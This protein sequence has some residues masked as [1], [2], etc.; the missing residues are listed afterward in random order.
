VPWLFKVNDLQPV[1]EDPVS[2]AKVE[3]ADRAKSALLHDDHAVL[4]RLRR[5]GSC[6]FSTGSSTT[7][8]SKLSPRGAC[9]VGFPEWG[10]GRAAR[11]HRRA[12]TKLRPAR[13]R[14][15]VVARAA[16]G[17]YLRPRG[18]AVQYSASVRCSVGFCCLSTP[19]EV[20]IRGRAP[21]STSRVRTCLWTGPIGHATGMQHHT[22]SVALLATPGANYAP[23]AL[24][25]ERTHDASGEPTTL[26]A[27]PRRRLGG[28]EARRDR[29][30]GRSARDDR[31]C[32]A[33]LSSAAP[34]RGRP[35]LPLLP[36]CAA[37]ART[38]AYRPRA[39]LPPVALL[40][41]R[42][43]FVAVGEQ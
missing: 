35:L 5:D 30:R 10:P 38:A 20:R 23:F 15:G 17:G 16:M 25:P 4:L 28:S 33:T 19:G 26:P 7:Q 18:S 14:G 29:Q 32:L 37:S 2:G 21:L 24:V 40:R 8:E 39:S 12:V 34:G 13:W 9:S 43:R 22:G 31:Q 27:S 1:A 42:C 41:A 11:G 36:P 3:I 6:R